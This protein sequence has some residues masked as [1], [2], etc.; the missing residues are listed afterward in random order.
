MNGPDLAALIERLRRLQ[1]PKP[2]SFFRRIAWKRFEHELDPLGAP[3]PDGSARTA[4]RK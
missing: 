2:S 3:R 4:G 1:P